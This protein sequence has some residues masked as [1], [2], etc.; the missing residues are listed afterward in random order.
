MC[1][2]NYRGSDYNSGYPDTELYLSD[3]VHIFNPQLMTQLAQNPTYGVNFNGNLGDFSA[4]RDGV[5]IANHF[6][7]A[8]IRCSINT[9]GSSRSAAWWARLARP[10]IAATCDFQCTGRKRRHGRRKPRPKLQ[11]RRLIDQSAFH[12]RYRARSMA[13]SP[14]SKPRS[15]ELPARSCGS[16]ARACNQT[17]A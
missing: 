17:A 3:I 12:G 10:E 14:A 11:C 15:G 6:A 9:N 7:D 16:A 4:S 1:P 13:S 8:G 5:E 2:R